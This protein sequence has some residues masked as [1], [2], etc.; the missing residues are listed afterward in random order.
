MSLAKK[1]YD[2]D[3]FQKSDCEAHFRG[4]ED[5]GNFTICDAGSETQGMARFYQVC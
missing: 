2:F 3:N 1:L 5:G 4:G